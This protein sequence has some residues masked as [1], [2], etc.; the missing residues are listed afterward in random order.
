VG[1]LLISA[2][3][4]AGAGIDATAAWGRAERFVGAQRAGLR[5]HAGVTLRLTHV[6]PSAVNAALADFYVFNASDSSCF[7]IVAGDDRAEE[8][9]AYGDGVLDMDS[10]PCNVQYWLE[11]Y[12][13][14]LETLHAH[15]EASRRQQQRQ[16]TLIIEPLVTARWN[17]T[18]PYNDMCPLLDGKHC[19]TGCVATA[20]AQVMHRW[21]FPPMAPALAAYTTSQ[22]K[23]AVPALPQV[24]LQWDEMLDTY[25]ANN[26]T[27]SQATAVATLMRYCGQSCKMDYGTSSGAFQ[28]NELAGMKL[29]GYNVSSTLL[30][31]YNYTD[32]EWEEML[33]EDL[34][35]GRPVLYGGEN[36]SGICHAFVIDGYDGSRYHANWGWGGMA[37][38]YFALDAFSTG[39]NYGQAMLYHVYPD[40]VEGLQP[41]YDVEDGGICYKKT[42]NGLRVV[43]A[44]GGYHG[45]IVIP[46]R[47]DFQGEDLPVTTIGPGAFSGCTGLTSVTIG[48][49]VTIVG[50]SAFEGCTGLKRVSI[51]SSVALVRHQAFLNC[52]SLDTVD[53]TS[54]DAWC[55]LQ[56]QGYDSSPLNYATHLRLNG[57]DLTCV[58][59]PEGVR[60]LRNDL[61][62][63]VKTLVSVT[64][65]ESV[66]RIGDYAFYK[67]TSLADVQMG[68]SITTIGYC[69]FAGCKVLT[70]V[71]LSSS[72]EMID[73]YAFKDCERMLRIVIPDKIDVIRSYS[74]YRCK[75]MTHVTLGSGVD[76]IASNAFVYCTALDTITCRAVVPPVIA[77][78]NSF[79]SGN[80]TKAVLE[81]PDASLSAYQSA[82]FWSLFTT[83]VGIDTSCGP[84]DVNGDGEVN[85]AD[86]NALIDV[87]LSLQAAPMAADVN[88]D[89][90]VNIADINTLIE[91]L[92]QN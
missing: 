49:A 48:A 20:M 86:I 55:D 77:R 29:F 35:A 89:G 34:Q 36:A 3:A 14:Q 87:I 53:I 8:I 71:A 69:A 9:L 79:D 75:R 39:Y 52:T 72:L 37:D 59:I 64:L 63:G 18:R 23:I 33:L 25:L 78:K 31:R 44:P 70:G 65:P 91:L 58:V 66:T 51:P 54:L 61:F 42:S 17:Q 88:A 24:E 16:D 50:E 13:R 73:R 2:L 74:F 85:I 41:V 82:Q 81:V 22:N 27:E 57:E 47:V 90:E 6:E 21:K 46:E 92:L 60:A 83:V 40:G 19:V 68:D 28:V 62:R 26:Y 43:N 38:G 30:V 10:L 80:F 76:S 15:P 7:V 5:S 32:A 11:G 1:L 12:C 45:D 56:F 67:C 4:A 84:A